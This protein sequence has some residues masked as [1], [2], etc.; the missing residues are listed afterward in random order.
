MP[1]PIAFIA[2]DEYGVPY[3]AKTF[4][5]I[6]ELYDEIRSFE[7]FLDEAS[8][9][10]AYAIRAIIDQLKELAHEQELEDEQLPDQ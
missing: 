1:F 6:E 10:K 3:A 7:D 2:D 9:S 5:S 4:S 8:A